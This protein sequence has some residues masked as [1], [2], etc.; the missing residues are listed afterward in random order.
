[1]RS[2]IRLDPAKFFSR[3]KEDPQANY[4]KNHHS[5]K[6]EDPQNCRR[7]E[8]RDWDFDVCLCDLH[9]HGFIF[10]VH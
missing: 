7:E 4:K 3:E 2:Q 10:P 6:Q 9:N 5:K 1:M 8:V